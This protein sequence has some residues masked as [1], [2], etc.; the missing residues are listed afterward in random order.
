MPR[1]ARF[2]A[3]FSIHY[4]YYFYILHYV[5]ASSSAVSLHGPYDLGFSHHQC[6]YIAVCGCQYDPGRDL[7]EAAADRLTA[8]RCLVGH[9]HLSAV[10]STEYHNFPSFK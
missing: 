3:F 9:L 1:M 8:L 6:P 10:A 2:C 5:V 4:V 7:N